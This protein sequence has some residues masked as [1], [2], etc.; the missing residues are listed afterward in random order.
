MTNIAIPGKIISI[1][2]EDETPFGYAEYLDG[3]QYPNYPDTTTQG[4]KTVIEPT[5]NSVSLVKLSHGGIGDN[6]G[7][8][9]SA[10]FILSDDF[11]VGDVVECYGVVDPPYGGQFQV[12]DNSGHALLLI[13]S[14]P[15]V[16]IVKTVKKVFSGTGNDWIVIGTSY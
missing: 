4:P 7:N 1:E 11:E 15:V 6:N 5:G 13:S 8:S 2:V 12:Y 10:G 16:K 9:N 14:S 3:F